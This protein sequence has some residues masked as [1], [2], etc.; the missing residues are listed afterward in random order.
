M[1]E[2]KLKNKNNPKKNTE[3]KVSTHPSYTE[4]SWEGVTAPEGQRR[5]IASKN[6]IGQPMHSTGSIPTA[7]RMTAQEGAF[8]A[9]PG[10][11]T[12]GGIKADKRVSHKTRV[13]TKAPAVTKTKVKKAARVKAKVEYTDIER[14]RTHAFPVSLVL[15]AVCATVLIMCIVTTGVQINEITAENSAL[16]SQYS[17]LE[18]LSDELSRQLEVRDDLR[19]VERMAKEELGMVKRDQ[20]DRYYLSVHKEDRIEIIDEVEVNGGSVFDGIKSFGESIVERIRD[21]FGA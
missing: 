3:E 21:Y 14:E 8:G 10:A 1:T 7:N 4:Y 11:M 16:K 2:A 9:L 15:M 20:V 19:V 17:E 13:G 18:E 12:G 5:P 6:G